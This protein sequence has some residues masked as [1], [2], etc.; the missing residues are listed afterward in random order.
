MHLPR[1]I[2]AALVARQ[3]VMVLPS[4]YC[5]PDCPTCRIEALAFNSTTSCAE[6]SKFITSCGNC[7]TCVLTYSIENRDVNTDQQEII[8]LISTQ[9]NK[10]L[11][12][13]GGGEIQQ[14]A[15][16]VSNLTAL[17]SRIVEAG[18][19][20]TSGA[21]ATKTSSSTTTG[22]VNLVTT[23]ASS[24]SGSLM[25]DSGDWTTVLST[26][27]WASAYFS[28][29]SEASISAKKA[30]SYSRASIASISSTPTTDS[31]ST[32]IPTPTPATNSN[33]NATFNSTTPLTTASTTAP[34]N[35]TWIIGPIIGSLLGMSTV[36]IVIFF[37]RRKQ[38]REFLFQQHL[39][40]SRHIPIDIEPYK[41]FGGLHSP[42]STSS[43]YSYG[44]GY[45]G[46]GGKAQLHGE[47]MEMRELQGREIMAPVELPAREPVGSELLTPIGKNFRRKR[48]REA[49]PASPLV[50]TGLEGL[51]ER[52]HE[53]GVTDI[54]TLSIPRIDLPEVNANEV[55]DEG[56]E[57]DED[58]IV[59][60]VE[61]P[62]P[63][64]PLQALFK[65]TEMRDGKA[66]ADEVRHETYYHP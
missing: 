32:L 61:W 59:E 35:K 58:E 31:I 38:H 28:A 45:L 33:T 11:N 34:L 13:P 51:G 53:K 49:S 18:S 60:E 20:T 14:Y 39:L 16:Q 40:R 12:T 63:M 1:F 6:N 8:P 54:G 50:S 44:D 52:K 19:S 43:H 47:S 15:L 26:A 3:S 42:A 27:T 41:N 10:C 48:K 29:L 21:T 36:F 56:E 23:P 55:R 7:Q 64:S 24:W 37:T 25:S 46:T 57:N 22:L 17:Y 66:D 2:A 4:S 65:K 9:L 62:L 30:S 5:S